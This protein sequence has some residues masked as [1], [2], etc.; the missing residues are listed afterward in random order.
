MN[1]NY[2]YFNPYQNMRN[3]PMNNFRN[4]ANPYMFAANT[5]APTRSAGGLLSRLIP[6]LGGAASA[7]TTAGTAA[8]SSGITFSGILSG[9]SKTLGVIN[10]ALPVIN[11]A[12]PIWNNAKTMFRMAKAINS[13]EYEITKKTPT[14]NTTNTST[15]TTTS[16]VKQNNEPTFFK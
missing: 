7:T 4:A 13:N 15:T 14:T 10:Q 9:A 3:I 16:N 2:N 5:A 12:K 1:N 8:A 6:G 11:Q